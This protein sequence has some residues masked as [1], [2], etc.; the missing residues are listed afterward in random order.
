[1]HVRGMGVAMMANRKDRVN[2][3]D[4]LRHLINVHRRAF[5][6]AIV[7]VSLLMWAVVGVSAWFASEILTELP[8]T[9]RL[10]TIETMAQATTLLDVHDTPAFTIF[11]E[12]RIEVPL[13]SISP[14]LVRAIIAIEDQRFYDHAGVDFVRV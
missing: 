12:Q 2:I 6:I 7:A 5:V 11:E 4:C 1:M 8:G 13:S 14:H 9:D 3:P 10:R